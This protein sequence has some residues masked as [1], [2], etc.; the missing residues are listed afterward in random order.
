M[1]KCQYLEK[2]GKPMYKHENDSGAEPRTEKFM[3]IGEI[4][5]KTYTD[6]VF[7]IG[8]FN[9]I[10]ICDDDSDVVFG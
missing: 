3:T 10:G 8:H 9:R 7:V 1:L 2:G 5:K 6:L 4:L